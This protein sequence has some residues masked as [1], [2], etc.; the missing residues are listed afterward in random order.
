MFAFCDAE[1]IVCGPFSDGLLNGKC[2][3]CLAFASATSVEIASEFDD[4]E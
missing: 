3:P 4:E 2:R 1:C